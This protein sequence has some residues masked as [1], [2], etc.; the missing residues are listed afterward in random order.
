MA[1]GVGKG[2]WLSSISKQPGAARRPGKALRCP[3]N[4]VPRG[5]L[6]GTPTALPQR[7]TK[8]LRLREMRFIMKKPWVGFHQ[9][10]G[11]GLR[12]GPGRVPWVGLVWD[13]WV[14]RCPKLP[15]LH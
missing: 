2:M 14:Q 8:Q 5:D 12:A 11:A 9:K 13:Q 4:P 10:G 6:C 7:D 3:A 1:K 15:P